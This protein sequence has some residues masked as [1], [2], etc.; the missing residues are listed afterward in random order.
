MPIRVE[1]RDGQIL[2]TDPKGLQGYVAVPFWKW[3]E[4]SPYA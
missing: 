3:A 2:H 4:N 1:I